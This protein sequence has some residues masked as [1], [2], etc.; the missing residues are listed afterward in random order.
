MLETYIT[1]SD[2]LLL[3]E[4]YSNLAGDSD[5]SNMILQVGLALFMHFFDEETIT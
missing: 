3:S 5:E 2:S 4:I 1:R